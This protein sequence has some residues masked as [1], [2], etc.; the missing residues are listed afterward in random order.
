MKTIALKRLNILGIAKGNGLSKAHQLTFL[1]ELAKLGYRVSNPDMLN[2]VAASF[3]MDYKHLLKVLA[4]KRGGAVEYVPLFKNF[5]DEI[6]NDS[7]YLIKRIWG[8]VGN[9]FNLFPEA[10]ELDNGVK[11]PK[12]LFNIYEFG[13]DPITQMQSKELY[14]LAVKE[15]ANKKGDCHVEWIDLRIVQDD[16]L[17]TELKTYLARLVYAK[18]SIKEELHEDLFRLLDFF[19]A[20]DLEANLVVFKETKSLLTKYFWNKG[21]WEQVVKFAQSATDV[22]R[23]FAALT[24]SDVSLNEKIKFPK[25]SRKARRT[26]LA[27]LEKSTSL[28]EDLNRYKGLWLEIG[29]YLHP[30]EYSKQY[31]RTAAIFD[32]LRNGKIETYNAKT[33]QL[34]AMKELDALLVHLEAKPGVYARKLHEVL[35][36]FPEKIDSILASFDK[37]STQIALKNLW[38]LKA[39]FSSI[40]EAE[41]RTIVNKKGKMKV[42]PNNAFAALSEAQVDRVVVCIER[43]IQKLLKEKEAWTDQ[44]VWIDPQLMNYTIPLQQR[45]ASDGL[46]TVGKGSRIKI[47]FTKVLR[48]FI[49]WKQTAMT[50]DLDLSCIQFD[51][52]FNYLGH[53]SYT[54]LLGTGILHSG[55]VQSAPHGAAE[56]IDITL[57]KLAPKVRYLAV[58]VHK[59]AGEHFKNMDCHAGWMLRDKASAKSKTFD[60]KTVANKFDLNGVGGYAIPLMVDIKEQEIIATDL[61]VS[62][63]QF[64]NNVEGSVNDVAILCAQLANFVKTRPV[65]GDLAAAHL[66]A[67]NALQTEFKENASITFGIND[68]TYNAT[69][70][71]QILTE[72]I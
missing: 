66:R 21:D 26:V 23:L 46:I 58:Q 51:E 13:A 5:P 15:N 3:L 28:P 8:Y 39:Y 54:K 50:T 68:C 34:L 14:E 18:A 11:V 24:N 65:L 36:R 1:A 20:D 2:E 61:Y 38:V 4:Q 22:L 25:L 63:I 67:R 69:D 41:Y 45:K 30:T 37:K 72:L 7:D 9:L 10:I 53:V 52:E 35:R 62:G 48:L 33:E 71:E 42:L 29:R 57:S 56:F 59:Y 60:I 55:D 31:P 70:I 47:D 43:A 49:Y 44:A 12:W 17:E 16:E 19:G 27:I 6:P 64:H 40:N 32:L